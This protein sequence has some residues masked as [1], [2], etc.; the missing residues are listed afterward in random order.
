MTR[1]V[2]IASSE[3]SITLSGTSIA[4]SVA[5]IT[6]AVRAVSSASPG[7]RAVAGWESL[8]CDSPPMMMCNPNENPSGDANA[9]FNMYTD[10]PNDGDGNT[11]CVGR[12][13][14]MKARAVALRRRDGEDV[15]VAGELAAGEPV[16]ITRFSEIGPGVKVSA[17]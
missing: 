16:V 1:I 17:P 3:T 10:C 8:Y 11:S 14:T 2:S 4:L 15:L 5:A 13:I 7:A 6:A 12:G 9:P